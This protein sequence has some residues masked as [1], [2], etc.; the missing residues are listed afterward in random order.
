MAIVPSRANVS[1]CSIRDAASIICGFEKALRVEPI[2][3]SLNADGTRYNGNSVQNACLP[4]PQ[5]RS[6]LAFERL[7]NPDTLDLADKLDTAF[8]R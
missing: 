3:R 8:L 6:Y 5:S 4:G 7:V 2:P 1:H